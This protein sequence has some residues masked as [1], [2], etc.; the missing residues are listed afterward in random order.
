MEG[1]PFLLCIC[2]GKVRNLR[3]AAEAEGEPATVAAVNVAVGIA[4]LDDAAGV[5][6]DGEKGLA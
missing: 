4:D 2:Q 6:E 3:R 1:W 5:F